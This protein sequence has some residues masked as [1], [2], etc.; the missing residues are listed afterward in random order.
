MIVIYDRDLY[1]DLFPLFNLPF[2]DSG[3]RRGFRIR[4]RAIS[5]R[6]H[7]DHLNSYKIIIHYYNFKFL[8]SSGST[9]FTAPSA[10]LFGKIYY[11]S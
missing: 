6:F 11:F 7:T 9:A 1:R 3:G 4:F 5:S 2:A 10:Q 8:T